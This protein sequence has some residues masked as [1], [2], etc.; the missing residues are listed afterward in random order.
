MSAPALELEIKKVQLLGVTGSYISFEQPF[1]KFPYVNFVLVPS[2]AGQDNV[3]AFIK[4]VSINGFDIEFS[5]CPTVL[6]I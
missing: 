6:R 3:N 4:N 5:E 1:I 2:L